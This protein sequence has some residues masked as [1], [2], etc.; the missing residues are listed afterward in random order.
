MIEEK[1]RG[2][3]CPACS[4]TA[5]LKARGETLQRMLAGVLKP[6]FLQTRTDTDLTP[7]QQA[8]STWHLAIASCLKREMEP[9]PRCG[10]CGILMGPGHI[11]AG[12]GSLCGTCHDTRR[13]PTIGEDDLP[14]RQAFGRRGWLSDYTAK[15]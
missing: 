5:A 8:A 12:T 13:T 14:A 1:P 10:A 9:H 11:E 15:H 6:S 3:A 2:T 4:R 7:R